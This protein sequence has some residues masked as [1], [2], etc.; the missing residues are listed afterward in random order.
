MMQLYTYSSEPFLSTIFF[1]IGSKCIK[2]I[3]SNQNGLSI[4]DRCRQLSKQCLIQFDTG[5]RPYKKQILL[6]I[7]FMKKL[8]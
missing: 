1:L 3:L 7:I 8:R 5:N 4:I 2:S 6:L